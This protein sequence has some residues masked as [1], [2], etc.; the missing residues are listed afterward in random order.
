M[1]GDRTDLQRALEVVR[2]VFRQKTVAKMILSFV[3]ISHVGSGM[4]LSVALALFGLGYSFV[5]SSLTL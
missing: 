4:F 3:K 5:A 2:T 1:R